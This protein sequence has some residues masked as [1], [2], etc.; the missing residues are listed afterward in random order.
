MIARFRTIHVCQRC[1][2]HTVI[3]L[4]LTISFVVMMLIPKLTLLKY[5]TNYL[6]LTIY[7][8]FFTIDFN[9]VLEFTVNSC[10]REKVIYNW[11]KYTGYHV[12]QYCTL[13]CN[14]FVD[15]HVTPGVKCND[16][17]CQL[18]SHKSDIDYF[19]TQICDALDKASKY[20]IPSS[21][22]NFHC[23]RF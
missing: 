10:F 16:P 14:Y 7:Q 22:I 15:I 12:F 19:Y 1:T 17:N 11:S 2:R 5:W 3:L 21:R 18:S 20:C 8:G 23:T 13:T 4:G 6:A 9:N